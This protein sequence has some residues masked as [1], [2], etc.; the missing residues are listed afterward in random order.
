M[1]YCHK[2]VRRIAKE[3]A[4]AAYESFAQNDAFHDMWPNQ[5]LFIAKRWKNFVGIARSTL[6]YMLG[7]PEH[8]DAMKA[9]LY[10]IIIADRELQQVQTVPASQLAS[11]LVQGS[12]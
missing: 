11:S 7:Q 10:E 3:L 1:S 2:E 6:V 8:S 9:D 5:N 12:A 4:G